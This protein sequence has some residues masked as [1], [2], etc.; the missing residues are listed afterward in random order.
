[1]V[2]YVTGTV[3]SAAKQRVTL[4]VGPVGLELGV[5]DGSLFQ[6]G[7]AATVHLYMHWNQ[8]QGPSL[9]GFT[10]SLEKEVFLLIISCSGI[11]PKIAL[12]VLAD[13]GAQGFLE[14]IQM[15]DERMLSKVSGIGLKK[16]EQ[17]IVQLKH[18]IEPLIA[19]GA[20]QGGSQR[21]MHWHTVSKALESLNYSRTEITQAMSHLK[22]TKAQVDIS[23]DQLLRQA[24]SFLSK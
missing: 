16:A 18:K 2:S 12:A 6:I 19:S 17:M 13:L 9:F 10:S 23:F 21:V 7:Q 15:G 11:G 1:M 20:M 22:S 5:P 4:A 8:E 3:K 24:L 14:A